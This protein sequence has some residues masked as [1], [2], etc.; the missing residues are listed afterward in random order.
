[1]NWTLTAI[2]I[3]LNS[4][5][6]LCGVFIVGILTNEPWAW[7]LA[8]IDFGL[9]YLG[10]MAERYPGGRTIAVIINL[11]SIVIGV[12]ALAVVVF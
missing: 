1:M 7:K 5:L 10:P 6:F 8:L 9:C 2:A 4:A 12:A 11:S 3:I